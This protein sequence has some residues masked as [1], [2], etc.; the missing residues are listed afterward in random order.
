VVGDEVTGAVG[1]GGDAAAGGAVAGGAADA[2]AP[3]GGWVAAGGCVAAGGWIATGGC[4]VAHGCV[5]VAEGCGAAAFDPAGLGVVAVVAG[6]RL[7]GPG[8]R[9]RHATASMAARPG[10]IRNAV[11]LRMARME[12]SWMKRWNVT[13]HQ[14]FLVASQ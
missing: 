7:Y 12:L 10:T 11:E 13:H 4:V 14:A 3:A 6:T 9:G 1:G 8:G 2:C 5:A